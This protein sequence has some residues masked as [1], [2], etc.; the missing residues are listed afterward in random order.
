MD[1]I[2]DEEEKG[3]DVLEILKTAIMSGASDIHLAVG[4]PPV[5]R[6]TGKLTRYTKDGE[7]GPI[8]REE[9]MKAVHTLMN[10]E[11][12]KYWQE[13]GEIDFSYSLLGVS[14]FRVNIYR[15]RGCPSIA[16]R[17]VPYDIPSLESLG[18]PPA[19]SNLTDKAYG[20]ILVTGPT[21]TGKSTTLAAMI[22]KINTE[23]A[24]HIIT[25]ED[26]IEYLYQHKKSIIDQRELGSDTYSLSGALRAALRQDPDVIMIGELRDLE[27]ISTAVTAAETGHL[28]MATLHTNSVA[29]S[30][31]RI[32]D[33]F[34]SGQQEQIKVQLSSTLQGI[35]TQQLIPKANGKGRALA[36]EV[37]IAIPAIR[38][39]I[40]EG[41]THQIATVLQ[42]GG[43]WGMQTMDMSLRD[44]VRSNVIDIEDALK[45]TNDRE[46][47][48]RLINT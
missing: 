26:P 14:R 38:N 39:L 1:M 2:L 5:F 7:I 24:S 25:V 47:L 44:M 6:I 13:H 29:Q 10:D 37:L 4:T 22:D 43:R 40:R 34:P 35:V 27:T 45:C 28:V 42:T 41:K 8:T 19:V 11:Q 36:A 48:S 46:N 30:I 18:I 17:P 9:A 3:M 12:F 23:R 33:V 20:L 21:G 15:Q 32:I 31:D 16:I